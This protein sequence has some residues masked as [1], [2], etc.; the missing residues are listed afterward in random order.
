MSGVC[1]FGIVFLCRQDFYLKKNIENFQYFL[2]SDPPPQKSRDDVLQFLQDLDSFSPPKKTNLQ[3]SESTTTTTTAAPTNPALEQQ[4]GKQTADVSSFLDE[5][6]KPSS[7]NVSKSASSGSVNKAPISSATSTTNPPLQQQSSI[8]PPSTSQPPASSSW[9]TWL[10]DTATKIS[11]TSDSLTKHAISLSN[12]TAERTQALIKSERLEKMGIIFFVY[13]CRI[14]FVQ[15][16]LFVGRFNR[17]SD[18]RFTDF[19]YYALVMYPT[20]F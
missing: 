19:Y 12:Q 10:T 2:M 20:S 6:A 17:S 14:R 18:Y 13:S 4:Q 11:S 16:H 9:S 1:F 8:S 15:S 3:K 5:F 7:T